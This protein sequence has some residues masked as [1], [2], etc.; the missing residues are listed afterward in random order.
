MALTV[1]SIFSE[2]TLNSYFAMISK[3]SKFIKTFKNLHQL[4]LGGMNG[5]SRGVRVEITLQW[6][7]VFKYFRQFNGKQ[8]PCTFCHFC[9][10]PLQ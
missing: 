4:F 8:W 7:N 5:S 2:N 1:C 9:S 10:E 6:A 3:L